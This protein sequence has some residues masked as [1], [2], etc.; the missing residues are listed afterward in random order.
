M[1][2][3]KMRLLAT[4]IGAAAMRAAAAANAN[5]LYMP[6]DTSLFPGSGLGAV[7]TVLTLSSPGATTTEAGSVFAVGTG[8]STPT[9]TPSRARRRWA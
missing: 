5:L 7:N 4:G 9:A 1:Q 3:K 2:L 6:A 8:V